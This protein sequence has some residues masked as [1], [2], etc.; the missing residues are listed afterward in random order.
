VDDLSGEF[1]FITEALDH[2]RIIGDIRPQQLEGDLFSNP[3]VK[4][5]VD[6]SHT[7]PSQFL[8]NIVSISKSAA[9]G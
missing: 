4:N 2:L 8:Q 1:Q 6:F 9:P 7:T 3:L 5:L